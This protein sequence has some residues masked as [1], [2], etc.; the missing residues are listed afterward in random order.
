[1]DKNLFIR[2]ILKFMRL[3]D[4]SN[5]KRRSNFSSQTKA[6]FN[7]KICFVFHNAMSTLFAR[8]I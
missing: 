1:M 7:R 5:M 2:L 6:A 3:D 4:E 8:T